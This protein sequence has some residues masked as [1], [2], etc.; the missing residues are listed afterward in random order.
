MLLREPLSKAA[1][2]F[3]KK[4]AIVCEEDRFTYGEFTGR[5]YRLAN[6]L[7]GLGIVKDGKVAILHP[8][9]HV[10]MEGY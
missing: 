1:R 6:G 8:N 9:C 2:F 5:V 7:N 10:F 4:E 3:S